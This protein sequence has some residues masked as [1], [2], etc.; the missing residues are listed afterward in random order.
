[1]AKTIPLYDEFIFL[2]IF[3][4]LHP[5]FIERIKHERANKRKNPK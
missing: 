5:D 2:D 1:M 3:P 4:E